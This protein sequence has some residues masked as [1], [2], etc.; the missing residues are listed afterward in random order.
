MKK[1]FLDQTNKKKKLEFAKNILISILT[2]AKY[3]IVLF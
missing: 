1:I 2:F 3:D